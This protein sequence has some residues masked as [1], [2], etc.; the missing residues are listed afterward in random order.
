M[1]SL[2]DPHKLSLSQAAFKQ[3]KVLLVHFNYDL[4]MSFCKCIF[5]LVEL[6]KLFDTL[7]V[8]LEVAY[9]VLFPTKGHTLVQDVDV[10]LLSGEDHQSASN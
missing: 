9:W 8:F 10:L 1:R 4:V 3:S 6:G 5:R 2:Y 7:V